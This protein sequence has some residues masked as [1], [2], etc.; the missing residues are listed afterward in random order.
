MNLPT[1]VWAWPVLLADTA[2]CLPTPTLLPS[3]RTQTPF[4]PTEEKTNLPEQSCWEPRTDRASPERSES[5]RICRITTR[6][7]STPETTSS[8]PSPGRSAFGWRCCR[9]LCRSSLPEFLLPRCQRTATPWGSGTRAASLWTSASSRLA[10]SSTWNRNW[11]IL[12]RSVFGDCIFGTWREI[13]TSHLV[14]KLK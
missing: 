12:R 5:R 7:G 9:W 1:P 10:S 4:S 11:R 3:T 6:T 2:P 14:R 13:G 8:G